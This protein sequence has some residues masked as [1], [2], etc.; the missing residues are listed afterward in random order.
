MPP[1]FP[2]NTRHLDPGDLFC[3]QSC[4]EPDVDWLVVEV[5][6][7]ASEALMIPA[8]RLPLLG[9]ADVAIAAA[10]GTGA[11]TL[12]CDFAVWLPMDALHA[13]GRIATLA[14][15]DVEHA[16]ERHASVAAVVAEVSEDDLDSDYR[17]W[18]RLLE[19]ACAA[20]VRAYRG[21]LDDRPDSPADPLAAAA[22][23]R[24]EV[25][26]TAGDVV[27]SATVERGGS[28]DEVRLRLPA[29]LPSP[30]EYDVKLWRGDGS[31]VNVV[32]RIEKS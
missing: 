27:W 3:L 31:V 26:D 12:R 23:D 17:E 32:V 18:R 9:A 1:A 24:L 30:G 20:V 11:L 10:T 4:S 15:T 14:A 21:R 5:D 29:G 8:D 22:G 25:R 6:D 28:P 2:L 7:A 16:R 19:S 13:E